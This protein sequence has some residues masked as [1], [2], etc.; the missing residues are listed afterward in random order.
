MTYRAK[1]CYWDL[2]E[3]P[4]EIPLMRRALQSHNFMIVIMAA[5]SLAQIQDKDSIPLIIEVCRKEQKG[6]D[7]AVAEASLIF[8]DDPRAQ[9][10]VDT[11]MSKERAKIWRDARAQGMKAF[12]Y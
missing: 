3:D 1:C 8:F 5:K 4:R 7:A 11:Y 10:A 9:S 2:T 6:L 12:G